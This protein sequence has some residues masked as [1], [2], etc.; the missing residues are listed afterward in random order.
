[1]KKNLT[2]LVFVIDRS[3][4]MGGMELDT[5]GGVNAV[6]KKNAEADGDAVVS[7]V[8]FDHETK[9]LVDRKPI[10][11]VKPLTS[12]DYT[13]RGTTALLDAVGGSVKF[14]E[15]IQRYMPA[16]YQPEKTIFVITTDGYEN[17]SRR[18]TYR[19]I[20]GL[21]EAKQKDGWEFLFLGA[22]IDAE[23]EA[24]RLGISAD[25]AATYLADTE[26]TGVMYGAVAEATCCMRM[27]P[28]AASVDASWKKD[29]DRD[30]HSRG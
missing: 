17:A 22:N 3:G 10:A 7:I 8:L 2:E 5:I 12:D 1:M 6:L 4:S 15:R 27:A 30:R 18:F 28:M 25:R 13:V 23:E 9:V 24:E 11:E 20:K 29:I 26:G 19:D 14:I 16:D 21:L